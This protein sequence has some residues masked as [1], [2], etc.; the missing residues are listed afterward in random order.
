V[1]AALLAPIDTYAMKATSWISV[2]LYFSS[3]E[4]N[5]AGMPS[6]MILWIALHPSSEK[7]MPKIQSIVSKVCLLTLREHILIHF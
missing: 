3:P 4:W 6:V 1:Q 2:L 7:H 5:A